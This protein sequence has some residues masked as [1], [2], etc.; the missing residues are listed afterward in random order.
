MSITRI[1]ENTKIV[2]NGDV[3]QCDLKNKNSDSDLAYVIEKVKK[4][5]LDRFGIVE[6]TDLD[7]VRSP[8]ISRFLSAMKK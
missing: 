2:V 3:D 1:G 4:A 6:L 8:L 7:I 5:N